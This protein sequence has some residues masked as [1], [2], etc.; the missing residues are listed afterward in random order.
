MGKGGRQ[1]KPEKIYFNPKEVMAISMGL[2]RV[3]EDIN[4]MKK[5]EYVGI[6]W[7]PEARSILADILEACQSAASKL[8]K[9]A[10][11]KCELPPY[12]EG[13]ENEFLTK[14]S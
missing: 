14:E 7:T 3:I 1:M 12:E 5:G 8:E 13:D 6:P 10:G 4:A 2:G 11:V 9:F